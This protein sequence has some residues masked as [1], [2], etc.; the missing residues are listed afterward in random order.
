MTW[1]NIPLTFIKIKI[2]LNYFWSIFVVLNT[3]AQIYIYFYKYTPISHIIKWNEIVFFNNILLRLYFNITCKNIVKIFQKFE[4]GYIQTCTLLE[5]SIMWHP[6]G[7]H[8]SVLS[9]FVLNEKISCFKFSKI[10]N[11]N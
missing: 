6:K 9:P 3:H 4:V 10:K 2:H 8:Y 1:F 7:G 5:S 11:F